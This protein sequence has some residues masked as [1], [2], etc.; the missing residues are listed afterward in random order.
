[1]TVLLFLSALSVGILKAGS[2]IALLYSACKGWTLF[3]KN[4]DRLPYIYRSQ[5]RYQRR[6]ILRRIWK[7]IFN[8]G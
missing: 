7:R 4:Y 8:R 2:F 3:W 6:F 1:M 5:W